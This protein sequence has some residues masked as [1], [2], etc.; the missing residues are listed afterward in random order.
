[1]TFNKENIV[2][3]G[4]IAAV[5]FFGLAIKY[6]YDKENKTNIEKILLLF[7]IVGFI[8]DLYFSYEFIKTLK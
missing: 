7:V 1:M 5:P 6:F 4:D 2:H 3:Y 8:F